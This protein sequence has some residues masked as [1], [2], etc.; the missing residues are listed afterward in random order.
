MKIGLKSQSRLA[1]RKVSLP[2]LFSRLPRFVTFIG[3][4]H[5]A[6]SIPGQTQNLTDKAI[7]FGSSRLIRERVNRYVSHHDSRVGPPGILTP[8]LRQPTQHVLHSAH[9]PMTH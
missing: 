9:G 8:S 6:S 4:P 1:T 7:I 2:R 3:Y 5:V